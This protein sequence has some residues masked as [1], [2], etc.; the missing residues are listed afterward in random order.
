MLVVHIG[1]AGWLVAISGTVSNY[2]TLYIKDALAQ[3][4]GVGDITV[5]GRATIR[6]RVWLDPGKL[7]PRG[8]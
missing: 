7:R 3:V 6:M 5:F 1:L 8:S 2:A 4:D